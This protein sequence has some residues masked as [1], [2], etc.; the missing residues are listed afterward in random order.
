MMSEIIA[1]V[2]ATLSN[3]S[4]LAVSQLWC[5][6]AVCRSERQAGLQSYPGH[7]PFMEWIVGQSPGALRTEGIRVHKLL[8]TNPFAVG[9]P[10]S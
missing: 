8:P 10:S 7:V 2:G 1:D 5:T 6:H 3:A 9:A 4:R